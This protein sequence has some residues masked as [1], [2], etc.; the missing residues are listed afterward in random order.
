MI[1]VTEK[2]FNTLKS[3]LDFENEDTEIISINIL[4]NI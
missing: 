3:S 4:L 2:I 1:K